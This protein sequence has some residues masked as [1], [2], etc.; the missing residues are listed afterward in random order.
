MSEGK[1]YRKC[2]A[3]QKTQL[4]APPERLVQRWGQVMG[5]NRVQTHDVYSRLE[6]R[7]VAGNCLI[8]KSLFFYIYVLINFMLRR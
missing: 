4:S 6:L 2:L 1:L 7:F 5:L 3:Y 8:I